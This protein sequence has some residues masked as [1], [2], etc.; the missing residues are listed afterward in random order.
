MTVTTTVAVTDLDHALAA[1]LAGEYA[2][3][4]AYG[5]VGAHLAGAALG[6][7]QRSETVHRNQRDSLLELLTA[8]PAPS[9]L[10]ALPFAVTSPASA[11]ALAVYVE[12]RCAV[13]WRDV[14]VAADRATRPTELAVFVDTA[15]RAAAFRRLGGAFPGTVA[16]PGLGA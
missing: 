13:L 3:I 8:P 6:L 5:V 9:P 10:Y 16:F 12:D 2:A 4:F 11:L 15:L 7:A 14:V 1:A